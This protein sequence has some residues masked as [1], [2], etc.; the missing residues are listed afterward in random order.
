MSEVLVSIMLF[1]FALHYLTVNQT[2]SKDLKTVCI[3]GNCMQCF[4][5]KLE[6]AMRSLLFCHIF[7]EI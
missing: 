4:Y 1:F 6:L 3:Q 2:N 5:Y 7:S